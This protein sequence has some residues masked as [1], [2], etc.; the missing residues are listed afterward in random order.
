MEGASGKLAGLQSIVLPPGQTTMESRGRKNH[1]RADTLVN[2]HKALLVLEGMMMDIAPDVSKDTPED[3]MSN[4]GSSSGKQTVRSEAVPRLGKQVFS[5]AMDSLN[6][7]S[8]WYP[9]LVKKGI[10]KPKALPEGPDAYMEGLTFL[11]DLKPRLEEKLNRASKFDRLESDGADG[12]GHE[13]KD[14]LGRG[15]SDGDA[16]V[17]AGKLVLGVG[18]AFPSGKSMVVSDKQMVEHAPPTPAIVVCGGE[19]VVESDKPMVEPAPPSPAIV[20]CGGESVVESG[21]PMLGRAGPC[22][23]IFDCG[24]D[25][26]KDEMDIAKLFDEFQSETDAE[27]ESVMGSDTNEGMSIVKS[28]K[29]ILDPADLIP[30]RLEQYSVQDPDHDEMDRGKPGTLLSMEAKAAEA[31]AHEAYRFASEIRCWESAWSKTCNFFT[32][33]TA[34]SSMQFTHYTPGNMSYHRVGSTPETLQIFSVKLAK[35]G[36]GLAWPLSVYGVVAARDIVDHNRN[37]LFSCS[38]SQAQ[39]LRQDD[40]FLHLIGPSR[41]IVFTDMV[42]FEIQLKVKAS[43]QIVLLES[44]GKALP[45]GFHGYIVLSRQVVSVEAEGVLDLALEA[46]SRSGDTTTAQGHVRFLPKYCGIS[47]DKC[48][49]DDVEV[50]ITVAWSLVATIKREL[51]LERGIRASLTV[52]FLPNSFQGQGRTNSRTWMREAAIYR[53]PRT[54]QLAIVMTG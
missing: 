30:T 42:D 9:N 3:H 41:A 34:L 51:V 16:K 19:S 43:S 18:P 54:F 46:Y 45:K 17:E 27:S 10:I 2:I 53:C 48:F 15:K 49:L 13:K 11:N 29:L 36:G 39:E 26:K 50:V 33:T 7:I 5:P 12:G 8:G 28:D 32:D 14:E 24:G 6:M 22:P 21:K 20:V 1:T 25:D 52:N 47:Q 31:A 35:I 38:R 44:K 40:P 37:I 23:D 4:S